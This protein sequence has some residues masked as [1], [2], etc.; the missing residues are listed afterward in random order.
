MVIEI[1]KTTILWVPVTYYT[2]KGTD[3]TIEKIILYGE[4]LD[5]TNDNDLVSAIDAL[6]D[7]KNS[8]NIPEGLADGMFSSL[9]EETLD[10]MTKK[11]NELTDSIIYKLETLR[12]ELRNPAC[13]LDD[14]VETAAEIM[15]TAR[16]F[17]WAQKYMDEVIDPTSEL[18][19]AEYNTLLA[20][21]TQ[22]GEWILNQ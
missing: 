6:V 18:S 4:E 10:T 19:N 13:T 8:A 20:M 14:E 5:L 11:F 16:T 9:F 21:L 22:Y 2:V 17:T 3:D 7:S 12:Y 1:C 15:S